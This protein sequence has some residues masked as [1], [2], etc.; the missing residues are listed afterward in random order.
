MCSLEEERGGSPIPALRRTLQRAIE[1]KTDVVII[2]TA[3][4]LSN[5]FELTMQLQ[6]NF[7]GLEPS[8][9]QQRLFDYRI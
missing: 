7:H 3:G 4:R 6:V 5:N 8:K 1:D 2:D 9:R